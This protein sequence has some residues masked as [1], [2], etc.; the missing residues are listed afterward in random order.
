MS[1]KPSVGFLVA[2]SLLHPL[3]QRWQRRLGVG[4]DPGE[5]GYGGEPNRTMSIVQCHCKLGHCGL[6]LRAKFAQCL[7]RRLPRV[8]IL[9]LQLGNE[10]GYVVWRLG[11]GAK[12]T[13]LKQN[14]PSN[15]HND[16]GHLQTPWLR[17]VHCWC[18]NGNR[19]HGKSRTECVPIPAATTR[20]ACFQKVG[21]GD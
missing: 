13:E 21:L 5:R 9:A 1:K 10:A 20:S 14:E 6:G 15:H 4:A 12:R 3:D 19:L 2:S 11:A 17:Y 7:C 18:G 8:G 16:F